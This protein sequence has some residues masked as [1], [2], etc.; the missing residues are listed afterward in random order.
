MS[1][2]MQ[3]QKH[4]TGNGKGTFGTNPT[5]HRPEV[6]HS[7]LTQKRQFQQRRN[8]RVEERGGE[9]GLLAKE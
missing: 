3:E 6:N 4:M 1:G 8:L 7:E 2:W 9:Q 5:E